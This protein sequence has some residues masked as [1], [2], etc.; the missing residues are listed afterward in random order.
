MS[1]RELVEW[2]VYY[3]L[4]PFGEERADARSALAASAL[5]NAWRSKKDKPVTPE[6]FMPFS[7]KPPPPEPKTPGEI[8]AAF[9]RIVGL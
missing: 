5:L 8:M 4:E 9:D 7:E 2:Q 1:A 3:E 6:M